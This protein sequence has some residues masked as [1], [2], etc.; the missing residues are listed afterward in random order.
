MREF[1]LTESKQMPLKIYT[2]IVNGNSHNDR[3]VILEDV[4]EGKIENNVSLMNIHC[5][6]DEDGKV[7][8]VSVQVND[9]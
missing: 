6:L 5:T 2:V 3:E 9:K 8:D 7:V 1:K 4:W